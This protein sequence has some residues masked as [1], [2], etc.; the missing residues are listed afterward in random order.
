MATADA[1]EPLSLGSTIAAADG[2]DDPVD[3][4]TTMLLGPAPGEKFV[5]SP[6]GSNALSSIEPTTLS[7]LQQDRISSHMEPAVKIRQVICSIP[8]LQI[9]LD[10]NSYGIQTD[11]KNLTSPYIDIVHQILHAWMPLTISSAP[12][13]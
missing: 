8:M 9:F 13:T 5:N 4:P 1:L 2:G 11:Y 3:S 7:H 12:T 6:T 10:T